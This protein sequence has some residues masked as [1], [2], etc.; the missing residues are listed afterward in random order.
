MARDF[1]QVRGEL[2][3]VIENA[4]LEYATKADIAINLD[5]AEELGSF[6]LM[7]VCND[8]LIYGARYLPIY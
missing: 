7:D 2:K 6:E 5:R 3:D 8:V 4:I 1:F